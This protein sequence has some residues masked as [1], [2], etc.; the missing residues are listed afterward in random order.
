MPGRIE[1]DLSTTDPDG[2]AKVQGLEAA[3]GGTA[4]LHHGSGSRCAE[5]VLVAAHV[6]GMGVRDDSR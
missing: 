1:R 5:S 6:I 4:Q 2:F 3:G